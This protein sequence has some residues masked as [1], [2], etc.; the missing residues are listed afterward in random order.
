MKSVAT[1]LVLLYWNIQGLFR[2][3]VLNVRLNQNAHRNEQVY[4]KAGVGG[5]MYH[6]G[7]SEI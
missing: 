3:W 4:V 6:R 2:P 7:V 1:P 5:A